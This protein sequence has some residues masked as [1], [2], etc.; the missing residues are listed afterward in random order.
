MIQSALTAAGNI[1]TAQSTNL[2]TQIS[3]DTNADLA[4]TMTELD[5]TQ[6]AYEAALESGTK[7]LQ[8]SL[9]DFLA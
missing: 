9:V 3:G 8:I 6:T 7:V 1:A 5:Q 4:Q 2:T